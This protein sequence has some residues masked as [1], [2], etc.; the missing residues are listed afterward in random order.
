MRRLAPFIAAAA[1]T[2]A[3]SAPAAAAKPEHSRTEV[4]PPVELAAGEACDFA[5][6]LVNT[7]VRGKVSIWEYDDGTV[8]YLERG[9]AAGYAENADGDRDTL[10]GGYR[11][12]IVFHPDDSVDVSASGT[13][14]VWYFAGDAIV[15]L[16][17]PGAYG[18]RGHGTE[19]YAADGSLTAARFFG[20][21]VVDL[22]AALTP[23]G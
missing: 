21:H 2:L 18:V 14:F 8:R 10:S 12:E 6:T 3:I 16:T 23:T 17:A 13:L 20:G 4:A 15:G 7:D 1:L 9:H 19:S 22:C 11:I 5:I